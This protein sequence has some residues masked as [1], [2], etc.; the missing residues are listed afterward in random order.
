MSQENHAQLGELALKRRRHRNTVEHSIDGDAREPFLLH[1][2]N[3]ELRIGLEQLGIDF[4]QTLGSIGFGLRRRIVAN[5]LIVDGRIVHVGPLG[6][7]FG[8]F[9]LGPIAIRLQAPFEHELGFVFFRRNQ[10]DHVLVQSR[11]HG[12]GFDIGNKAVLVFALG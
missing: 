5:R 11:R 8:L 9:Q 7:G 12:V 1:Q 6:F 2:R 4:C 3:T 10:P